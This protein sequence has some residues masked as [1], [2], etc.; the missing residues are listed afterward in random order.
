M[1]DYYNKY[2]AFKMA[3]SVVQF[4]YKKCIMINI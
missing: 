2:E 1:D 3:L 4:K